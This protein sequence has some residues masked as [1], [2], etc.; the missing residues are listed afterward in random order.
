[1]SSDPG[2][3]GFAKAKLRRTALLSVTS[4][5]LYE[6]VVDLSPSVNTDRT[7]SGA[8]CRS[9]S[10]TDPSVTAARKIQDQA[11]MWRQQSHTKID[12]D[13]VVLESIALELKTVSSRNVNKRDALKQI[14]DKEGP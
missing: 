7:Q 10:D 13:P 2:N 1:V 11:T 9:F 4:S 3:A 6:A 8:G 12:L 5:S 14:V